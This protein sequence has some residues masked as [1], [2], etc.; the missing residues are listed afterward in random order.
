MWQVQIK[1]GHY[2]EM[3]VV[4]IKRII[5]KN[6]HKYVSFTMKN[7]ANMRRLEGIIA[8]YECFSTYLVIIVE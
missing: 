5:D 7:Y 8:A 3:Q 1:V 2:K 6:L 4:V